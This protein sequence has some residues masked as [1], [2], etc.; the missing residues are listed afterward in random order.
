MLAKL[1]DDRLGRSGRG[2]WPVAAAS[3]A[4]TGS[5]SGPRHVLTTLA[6]WNSDRHVNLRG[7]PITNRQPGDSGASCR[8]RTIA[9]LERSS[10]MWRF[11]LDIMFLMV[12]HPVWTLKAG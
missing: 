10:S 8:R 11:G 9:V 7:L 6:G 5:T 4:A 1:C 3:Q 12:R 2:C